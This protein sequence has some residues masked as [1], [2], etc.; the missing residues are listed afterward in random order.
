MGLFRKTE[1]RSYDGPSYSI[2]DPALAE[3][4]GMGGT[5]YA[6]VAVTETSALG[7]T[8]V[9]RAVSIISGTIAG[10]PLK[11]YR[12]GSDG[13]QEVGSFLDNPGGTQFTPFEWTELVLV[14]LLL[15]GNA[16]LLHVYNGAGGIV[17]LYPIHPG[18]VHVEADQQFGKIFKVMG[19]DGE[20]REYT[21]EDLT[22]IPALGT[23]GLVGLS[24][25][26]V[27]RNA[28]G[29]GIAGDQAAARMFGNGMMLGGMITSEEELSKED[30][31]SILVGLKS[32]L[33]SS[34]NAGDWPFINKNLKFTPWTVPAK[35]AQFLESREHQIT[36]VARIFGV[37]AVLLAEDGASTW[38]SGIAEL[39]RGM[40]KFTLRPW[41]SRIEQHLSR[42]LPAPRFVEF[43]Y[44]SLLQGTPAE[45]VELLARQVETGLLTLNEARAIMNLPA[46]SASPEAPTQQEN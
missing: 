28:L 8:A 18:L 15:H 24:P 37:P 2:G 16:Y 29:T 45:E 21:P 46:I 33:S 41:T 13:R 27:A 3:Y 17:E 43:E 25:I 32:K 20:T 7:L 39:I 10:L 44:K 1:N 31:E 23:D 30:A 4:L 19:S 35:D 6:G 40:Q 22:H 34:K 14:H 42:L 36:E 12:D 11:S 38:G 9:Y 5:S 26:C